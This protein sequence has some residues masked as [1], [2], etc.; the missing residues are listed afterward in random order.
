MPQRD[1]QIQLLFTKVYSHAAKMLRVGK[2]CCHTLTD[3]GNGRQTDR[4]K[5]K[6]VYPV[7]EVVLVAVNVHAEVVRSA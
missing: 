1:Q 6:D 4:K 7:M 5:A 2:W 3:K